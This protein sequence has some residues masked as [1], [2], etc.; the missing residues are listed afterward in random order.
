MQERLFDPGCFED[1]CRSFIE[2]MTR[3]RREHL[4]DQAGQRH[5]LSAVVRRQ[6]EIMDLLLQGYRSEAWKAELAGAGPDKGAA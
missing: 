4:A 1:F 2:E 3:L 6:K 5:E